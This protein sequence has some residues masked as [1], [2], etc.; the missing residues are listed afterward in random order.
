MISSVA[1]AAVGFVFALIFT[2]LATRALARL[3]AGQ[4]IRD[5]NPAAHQAKRG[6]PTMGGLVFI[7]GTVL[8]YIVGHL[9]MNAL[10][11]AQIV[12]PGPTM[13]GFVL[14]GLMVFCG[15]IGFVD[16]F[17]KVTKKNTAGLSGRWKLVLQLLVGTGFGVVALGFPST[18]GWSV[19]S[20]RLSFV[21]EIS[22]LD[23]G[24]VGAVV[25]FIA[26]VMAATNAVNLTDGLDGLA[27][28][29]SII[30][31]TAYGLISFWQYRHWCADP[32]L[33]SALCY[34]ARDPLETALVAGGA[35]GALLGFLWWN[36]SPARIIMGDTG[37]MALGG[38][39]AGQAVAT[40]TVLLLPLLAALFVTITMSRIIQYV[41]FKTTGRRVFRMSPLHHHF[42][43]VGWHEVTIVTRFW[44]IAGAGVAAALALFYG[45]FLSHLP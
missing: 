33:Q 20:T 22:W 35:A 5:I 41:S 29:T 24:Q 15:G 2:P 39:I 36:T 45:D 43:L 30:V 8:A 4:P 38:L 27:T 21:R 40:R 28:G 37:S 31:L 14:L 9:V 32:T 7:V 25:V 12:P 42:E 23:V 13:T 3:R 6:T 11:E 10:P 44:I 34:E 17:L 19:S 1:A 16:D 26:I 18:A